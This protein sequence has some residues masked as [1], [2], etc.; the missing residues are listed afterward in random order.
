MT[1]F[2]VMAIVGLFVQILNTLGYQARHRLQKSDA[3]LLLIRRT[4]RIE[5]VEVSEI[6]L[7]KFSVK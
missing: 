7:L 5:G 6:V 3:D 2:D 4:L 1:I